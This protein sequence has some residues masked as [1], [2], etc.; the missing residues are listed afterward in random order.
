MVLIKRLLTGDAVV[1]DVCGRADVMVDGKVKHATFF[2]PPHGMILKEQSGD[3]DE[4]EFGI[5]LGRGSFLGGVKLF[6]CGRAALFRTWCARTDDGALFFRRWLVLS[7]VALNCTYDVCDEF[8]GIGDVVRVEKKDRRLVYRCLK[9][10]D[11]DESPKIILSLEVP[12]DVSG[13]E[14]AQ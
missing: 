13:K 7:S 4:V 1:L 12:Y 9:V 3:G 10:H 5:C 14:I 6:W 11:K 2:Y 8:K